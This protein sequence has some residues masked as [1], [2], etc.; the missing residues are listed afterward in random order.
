[1]L[2][3]LWP[4]LYIMINAC[5]TSNNDVGII[6]L[7]RENARE[8]QIQYRPAHKKY[9]QTDCCIFV[10]DIPYLRDHLLI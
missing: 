7:A 5:K 4:T 3:D 10:Q 2:S 6:F 9:K 1:M 8:E